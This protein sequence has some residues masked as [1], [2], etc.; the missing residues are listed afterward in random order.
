ME[1]TAIIY[2]GF[3]L[4]ENKLIEILLYSLIFEIELPRNLYMY[5]NIDNTTDRNIFILPYFEQ[6]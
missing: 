2:A 6:N 5:S 1:L 3:P 4:S